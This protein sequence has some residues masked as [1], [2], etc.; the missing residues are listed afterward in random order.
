MKLIEALFTALFLLVVL[1][2]MIFGIWVYWAVA[3]PESIPE[4]PK[5]RMGV[6]RQETDKQ[7]EDES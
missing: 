6:C 4:C 7:R 2:L 1:G 3:S 5:L